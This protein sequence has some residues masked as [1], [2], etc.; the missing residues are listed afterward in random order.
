MGL[1][2]MAADSWSA[3]FFERESGV[4][5]GVAN[6]RITGQNRAAP[7]SLREHRGSGVTNR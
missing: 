2:F 1:D 6:S 3:A 5:E 7:H 4:L